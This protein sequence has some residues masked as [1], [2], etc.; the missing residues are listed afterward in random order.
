MSVIGRL[1]DQVDEILIT[2]LSR[3]RSDDEE[4]A[5]PRRPEADPPPDEP[6]DKGETSAKGDELPVW[7]L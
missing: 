4:P 5:P 1:D 7:L 3:R 2:P 6:A